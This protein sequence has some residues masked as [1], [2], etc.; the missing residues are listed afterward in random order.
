MFVVDNAA[1][2]TDTNP[3]TVSI[4]VPSIYRKESVTISAKAADNVGVTKVEFYVNSN[5]VCSVSSSPYDCAW[6]VPAANGKTYRFQA[7]AY[8]ARGNAGRS[9]TIY[10]TPPLFLESGLRRSAWPPLLRS[11]AQICFLTEQLAARP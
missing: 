10:A 11:E 8:D 4:A 3:P 5:L 2:V 6:K 1:L 7:V 9:A